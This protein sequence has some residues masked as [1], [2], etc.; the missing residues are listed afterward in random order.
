MAILQK[1]DHPNIVKYHETYEDDKDIYLVMELCEGG[2]L[3][4][5]IINAN[6]AFNG[7]DYE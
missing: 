4:T 2:E 7:L 3:S 1:V 6:I 5:E